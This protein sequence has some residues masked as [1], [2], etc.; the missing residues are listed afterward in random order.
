MPRQFPSDVIP[1]VYAYPCR[2]DMIPG[3]QRYLMEVIAQTT[4]VIFLNS[5]A[6]EGK[7]FEAYR[8]EVEWVHDSLVL[9]HK[10]F[11]FRF[12]RLGKKLGR[13][14]AR[15][16][17]S[18]L[19]KK[20]RELGVSQYIYWIAT[21]DPRYLRGMQ[22]DRLVY[23]CIDP[24]FDPA[25]MADFDRR[26]M[27]IIRQA[28]LVFCTAQ[29]LLERAQTENPN[30]RLLPNAC[31]ILYH[32]DVVS[33]LPLP[34]LLLGK[35]RPIVGYMGTFDARVDTETLVAVATRLPQFTFAFVGRVNAD[36]EDRV[37]PLR[38]LPNV[39]LPGAVSMEDGHAYSAAFDV[40]LIPFIPGP[41]GDAINSLKMY[42]YLVAGTPVVSTWIRECAS[43]PA[44][45]SA[46]K[47][48][49]EFVAAVERAAAD[50]SPEAVAARVRY[51]MSNRWEDR[52]REAVQILRES[53]L[54]PPA[55]IGVNGKHS[56]TT[57]SGTVASAPM[58]I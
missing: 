57:D 14:G 22:I 55:K 13:L 38:S 49:D 29:I 56:K 54:L 51:A 7:I 8:P 6:I 45:V 10:A 32:R 24:C 9:I 39:V 34:E 5:T 30:V 42:M 52:G 31:D 33:S 4:P 2:W 41:G 26:E 53:N 15:L 23:D 18:W 40:G 12:T 21:P 50:T 25:E 27:S 37:R 11:G 28:K 20:L 35:P 17:A 44:Q 58:R 46:T 47:T 1:I 19:H 43:R 16:D 3:R 36:Q 48:V